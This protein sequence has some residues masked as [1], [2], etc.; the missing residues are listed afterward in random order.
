MRRCRTCLIKRWSFV[1]TSTLKSTEK[2]TTNSNIYNFHY[3]TSSFVQC[4]HWPRRYLITSSLNAQC[5][6]RTS[7]GG[8]SEKPITETHR[9]GTEWRWILPVMSAWM[10]YCEHRNCRFDDRRAAGGS[11]ENLRLAMAIRR[12]SGRD[13]VGL[14]TVFVR[15]LNW[16]MMP[17]SST[18]NLSK[19]KILYNLH[20][21]E[22]EK[23]E[24]AGGKS[25][26]LC[27]MRWQRVLESSV[28]DIWR[29]VQTL[30]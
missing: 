20:G 2:Y 28:F 18:Y 6:K 15:S 14:S 3:Y 16:C 13:D 27:A 4:K 21:A 30:L 12:E 26:A 9:N 8:T 23:V 10:S 1:D 5:T 22:P 25:S 19:L 24:R 17:N 7:S 29:V 11:V